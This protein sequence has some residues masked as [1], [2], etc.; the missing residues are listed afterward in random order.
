MESETTIVSS[1]I[2]TTNGRTTWMIGRATSK[3]PKTLTIPAC[4]R[5]DSGVGA[6][7]VNI[8]QRIAGTSPLRMIPARANKTPTPVISAVDGLDPNE[9]KGSMCLKC[10]RAIALHK[11]ISE[12]TNQEP[13]V[14]EAL[15][16]ERSF[17]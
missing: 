8:S 4:S 15:R 3:Y 16:D 1:P 9:A 14:R 12:I 6:S 11:E 5:A 10:E 17:A 7:I 13:M 2:P